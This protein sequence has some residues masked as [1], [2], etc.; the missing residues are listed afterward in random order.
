MP[1]TYRNLPPFAGLCTF[2]DAQRTALSVEECVNWMKRHH[3]VLVRLHEILTAR[4]TAEP[5]YELK[6]AF[7]HHAYLCAEHVAAIRKRVSGGEGWTNVEP[8]IPVHLTYFTAT[9]DT[10]GRLQVSDDIY[11]HDKR[12]AAALGLS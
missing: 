10:A 4:I 7:S 6:T 12:L 11:G 3:Y 9:V 8:R 1:L 2:E 5:V